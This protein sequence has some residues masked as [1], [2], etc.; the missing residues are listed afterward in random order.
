MGL[1]DP[2]NINP[3][4]M[5]LL[6]AGGAIMSGRRG[7]AQAPQ[8]FAGGL[9]QGQQMQQAQR[10]AAM[11]EQMAAQ[12]MDMQRQQLGMQGER[13][14]LERERFDTERQDAVTQRERAQQQAEE[15]A[16]AREQFAQALQASGG[17]WS[18]QLTAMGLRANV[19]GEDLERMA[20]GGNLGRE[21]LSFQNGVGVDSFTGEPR[22]AVP[23]VNQPFAPSIQGGQVVAAPN[24]PVQ[25]FQINR[26]RAG[27]AGGSRVEVKMG[28]GI[29]GQVGPML[30]DSRTKASGAVSMAD[31]A[32]RILSALDAGTVMV[33]PGATLKLRGAQFASMFGVTGDG[34][35]ERTRAI[36]RSLAE[37]SI[38]ARKE[39]AGQGQVT[40]NE[41]AA[42]QKALSGDIDDLTSTEL[43]LIAGLTL[44]HSARTAQQH[45]QY[46]DNIPESMRSA[47]GFYEVRG[48]DRV[49]GI[50]PARYA[51]P[52]AVSRPGGGAAP[53]GAPPAAAQQGFSIRRLP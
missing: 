28:D 26:A 51:M 40:E 20:R 38:E 5:G 43:R 31:S 18:P 2:Q 44:R 37:M 21:K 19:K 4:A 36:I 53:A 17:Q 29:A 39:L 1:L 15:I 9:M 24:Q 35:I 27:A 14:G 32:E 52:A 22:A 46:L 49:L 42:V 3:F 30:K 12:Q 6:G 11:R 33:G 47:R 8:A 34:A 41:A 16:A 10:A 45:Q 7:I 23:D 48:M 13:F 50:D 25:D